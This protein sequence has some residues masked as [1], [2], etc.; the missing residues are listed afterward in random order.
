MSTY[1]YNKRFGGGYYVY[2][3]DEYICEVVKVRSLW[4]ASCCKE[5]GS[6]T[7]N[8]REN[9]VIAFHQS[10]CEHKPERQ[11][12]WT[13]PNGEGDTLLVGGCCD[14]GYVHPEKKL[15]KIAPVR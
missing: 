14:C 15:P 6:K 12:F 11:Y 8:T 10:V 5:H 1:E 9:A 3:D 13:V 4:E 2:L 7:A